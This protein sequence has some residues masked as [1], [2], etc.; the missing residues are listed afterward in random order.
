MTLGV[1]MKEGM[2]IKSLTVL[3]GSQEIWSKIDGS[4]SG[5]LNILCKGT[6][7]SNRI[8]KIKYIWQWL[9]KEAYMCQD[10]QLS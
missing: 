7:V 10:L 3:E 6:E 5:R 2:V 1:A 4:S 8:I 9:S